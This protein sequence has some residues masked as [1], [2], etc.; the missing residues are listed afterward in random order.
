MKRRS[1]TSLHRVVTIIGATL[2]TI[3][4]AVAAAVIGPSFGNLL[5][6]VDRDLMEYTPD[7]QF[8]QSFKPIAHPNGSVEVYDSVYDSTGR[9]HVLTTSY[10]ATLSADLQTWSYTFYGANGFIASAYDLSLRGSQAYTSKHRFDL[11]LMAAS[12]LTLPGD[13]WGE[14]EAGPDGLIYAINTGNPR[15]RMRSVDPSDF[16]LEGEIQLR[17]GNNAR[18]TVGSLAFLA[19]GS[20]YAASENSVFR[21]SKTGQYLDG[22]GLTTSWIYDLELLHDGSLVAGGRFGE[23]IFLD[24]ALNSYE[25]HSVGRSPVYIGVVP[26]PSVLMLTLSLPLLLLRRS[27]P[28]RPLS[29]DDPN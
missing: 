20:F 16:S 27:R 6:G 11:N 14:L 28:S 18:L 5:I 15:Y 25:V 26:E 24:A 19:D 17:D 2:V 9:I 10:L 29:G 23:L 7:G 1:F 12:T 3:Q 8:V 22:I 4:A 13:D 21:F